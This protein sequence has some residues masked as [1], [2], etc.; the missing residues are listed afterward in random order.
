LKLLPYHCQYNAIELALVFCKQY[1]NK[2]VGSESSS[3]NKIEIKISSPQNIHE[4]MVAVYGKNNP[5]Y[6]Q[7]KYWYKR[8]KWVRKSIHNDPKCGRSLEARVNEITNKDEDLVLIDRRGKLSI[9]VRQIGT[10][11]TSVFKILY[12]NL[13]M[14]KVLVRWI[15]ELVSPDQKP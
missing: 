6:F 5:S 3:K 10:S 4:R 8:F 2:N 13:G 15:P 9:I 1:Y 14:S 12:E 11:E 7:D